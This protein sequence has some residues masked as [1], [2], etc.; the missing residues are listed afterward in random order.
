MSEARRRDRVLRP[1]LRRVWQDSLPEEH[2]SETMWR[3]GFWSAER[4]LERL[5]APVPLEGADVL[6]VGCGTG[7]LCVLAVRRG[8]RS[9]TGVDYNPLEIDLGRRMIAAET[10][11][12]AERVELVVGADL[13][14]LGDRD[15]DV[16]VSKDS[17]EHYQ[18]P[19]EM[20][21][22]MEGRLRPGGHLAIGFGPLWNAPY[23]PHLDTRLPW[24]HHLFPER[25]LL[26]EWNALRPG[27]H[28]TRLEDTGVNRMT[29][30]RFERMVEATR[31]TRVGYARNVSDHPAVRAMDALSRVRPLRE[32]MVT[33]VYGVWRRDR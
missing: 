2:Y 25:L 23:G 12:A 4:F 11:D 18:Q 16:I 31:L 15:F 5:P 3:N 10:P 27:K 22:A 14:P 30:A 29:L 26:E 33:N 9:A 21:A 1:L 19:E 6:D 7:N 8:A 13:S 17:F 24:V 20:F 28:A 32:L